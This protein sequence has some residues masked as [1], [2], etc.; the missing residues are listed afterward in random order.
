MAIKWTIKVNQIPKIEQSIEQLNGKKV[1]IGVFGEQAWLAAIH[2]HG[3]VITPTKQ[4]LTVPCSPKAKG[5]HAGDFPNLF[6]GTSKSGTKFLAIPKGQKDFEV[7][8][9]LMKRVVIPERAFLRKGFDNHAEKIINKNENLLK[10]VLGGN[11]AVESYLNQ[12]GMQLA[13]K[14]KTDARDLSSPP[15]SSLTV[16]VKGSSNPLVDTGE[17]IRSIKHEVE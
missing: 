12:I 10:N 7:L 15:N 11:L 1:K 2:E 9:I 6:C 8:F 4:Y 13:S 14:I 5:K 16:A 3:C 17:M